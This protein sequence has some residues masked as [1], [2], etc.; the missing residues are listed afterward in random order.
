MMGFGK[1]VSP[2]KNMASFWISMLDFRGVDV[3]PI[4]HQK[5]SMSDVPL[6]YE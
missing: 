3:F 4:E 1:Y 5:I 2:A 6:R